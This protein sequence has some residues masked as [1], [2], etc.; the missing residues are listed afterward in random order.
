MQVYSTFLMHIV[1]FLNFCADPGSCF[2]HAA[3]LRHSGVTFCKEPPSFIELRASQSLNPVLRISDCLYASLWSLFDKHAPSTTK[4]CN[5]NLK[6]PNVA[7]TYS[8][9]FLLYRLQC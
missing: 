9:Y 8:L 4:F 6:L 1:F 5:G 2:G 3:H 7:Y